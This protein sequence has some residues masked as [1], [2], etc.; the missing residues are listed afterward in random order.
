MTEILK[1]VRIYEMGEPSSLSLHHP[2]SKLA[3][4]TDLR[5]PEEELEKE[6]T[7]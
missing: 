2:A 3:A 5:A 7:Y 1:D 6:K 4:C